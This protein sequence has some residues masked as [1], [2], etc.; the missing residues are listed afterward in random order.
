M[1]EESERLHSSA[2]LAEK[3]KF[4][5][6]KKP[7]HLLFGYI[8]DIDD[9]T[10][11]LVVTDIVGDNEEGDEGEETNTEISV[12]ST[13]N[14]RNF[15]SYECY[16]N[17][18]PKKGDNVLV[19]I[20]FNGNTSDINGGA[21]LVTEAYTH[22]ARIKIPESSKED[23]RAALT[24]LYKYVRSDGKNSDFVIKD[25]KV[26]DGEN[27][28]VNAPEALCITDEYAEAIKDTNPVGET[29]LE[30]KSFIRSEDKWIYAL[31]IIVLGSV[32]GIAVTMIIV[33][34]EKRDNV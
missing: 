22:S 17:L 9:K 16:N 20:L 12:G 21:F 34:S 10:C 24:A 25:T 14:I 18:T 19:S 3:V 28:E 11:S 2:L 15:T 8:K 31:G 1:A 26:Y 30:N 13:I 32:I 6:D 27:K 33:K 4:I 5:L 23:A 29:E 7:T